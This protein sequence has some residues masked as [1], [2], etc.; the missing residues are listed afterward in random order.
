MIL[1]SY[2]R[3]P[4]PAPKSQTA[5][6]RANNRPSVSSQLTQLTHSQ[7]DVDLNAMTKNTAQVPKGATAE[8]PKDNAIHVPKRN[9]IQVPKGDRHPRTDSPVTSQQQWPP[10]PPSPSF[11]SREQ[12]KMKTDKKLAVNLELIYEIQTRG[13]DRAMSLVWGFPE[14]MENGSIK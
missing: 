2:T 12:D 9:A 4:Y 14:K 10:A 7:S 3:C 6:S 13:L 11:H 1:Q 8:V 5:E